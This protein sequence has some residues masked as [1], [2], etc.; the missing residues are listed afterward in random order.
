MKSTLM[1]KKETIRK[2]GLTLPS[3]CYTDSCCRD[4]GT[5]QSVFPSL[6]D[7]GDL[8]LLRVPEDIE[9]QCHYSNDDFN[10]AFRKITQDLQINMNS[11]GR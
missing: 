2:F 8:S 10:T 1:R 6:R 3:L 11:S 4:R 7:S 9:I 5:V